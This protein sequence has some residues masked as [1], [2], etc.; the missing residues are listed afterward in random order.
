MQASG[1]SRYSEGRLHILLKLI[2]LIKPMVYS[3]HRLSAQTFQTMLKSNFCHFHDLLNIN[4]INDLTITTVSVK[5]GHSISCVYGTS[6]HKTRH[7]LMYLSTFVIFAIN[8]LKISHN[9]TKLN[10]V[11]HVHLYLLDFHNLTMYLYS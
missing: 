8:V 3:Q 10:L 9:L 4:K 7:T 11:H 2:M 6:P 1:P 5:Y